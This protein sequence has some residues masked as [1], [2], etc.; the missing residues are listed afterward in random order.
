VQYVGGVNVRECEGI[1]LTWSP[2][3]SE[4]RFPKLKMRAVDEQNKI[5]IPNFMVVAKIWEMVREERW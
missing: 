3:F 5:C 2:Q 1:S 4:T